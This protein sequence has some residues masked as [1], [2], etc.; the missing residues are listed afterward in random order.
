M[1][2]L[3]ANDAPYG[4]FYSANTFD[5]QTVVFN[6]ATVNVVPELETW[7]MMAAGIGFMSWKMRRRQES[8]AKEL[9]PS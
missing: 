4:G 6:G 5:P 7:A 8:K 2:S 1:F 3:A 9:T